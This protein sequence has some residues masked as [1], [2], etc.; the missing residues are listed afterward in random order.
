MRSSPG[1][2]LF[3]GLML[4]VDFYVFQA[5]KV[6]SQSASTKTRSIL[7]TTYWSISI[8]SVIFIF[9]LPYLNLDNVQKGLRGT[10]FAVII[11]LFLAKLI[12]CIFFLI[13][14]IR[15]GIQWLVGKLYFS[16]TEGEGM[17]ESDRMSRSLFLSWLGLAVGGGLFGSLFY[18][19]SNKYNYAIK[20][21]KLSFENLPEAFKGLKIVQI[22]DVHSGS[23]TDKTGV[24]KG[25][26]LILKQNPDLILFT[27][28]LVNNRANEMEDYIDVFSQLKA[29]MGVYSILGNHDYGDYEKWPS[30]EA[31]R[32]NLDRLK[33]IHGHMGWRLLLDEHVPL[34]K[35]GQEIGLIGI[36]NWSALKRFPKYGD[37]SK[38]YVG[39][40]KYP[41]KIL[42]SHDPTH[43]DAEVRPKFLDIDLMLAGHTHGMQFGVE[44]PG[45]RWSPVQYVYRQWADLYKEGSQML[46]VN[47]GYGFIGY[48]GRVGILPEIT[49]I[50]L[51]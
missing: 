19:F 32:E 2:I 25:I 45:F 38:A 18:G 15:R 42:M 28:D 30:L 16:Q 41:F 3:I 36:Q 1:W 7:F 44:I 10:F 23:F 40:E 14:D 6:V 46:Y 27:G 31:K 43:W 24:Q 11:G 49:V 51:A 26:D 5:L 48:P 20:R 12:A 4:A 13:D 33:A 34:E 21:R 35:N 22:S 8:L 47:R 29:P 37:L 50:E 9:I 17:N 39:A